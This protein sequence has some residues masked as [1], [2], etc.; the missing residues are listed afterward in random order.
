MRVLF[1]VQRYGPEVAG[2]AEHLCREYATRLAARGHDVHVLTSRALSYVDWSDHFP[3]GDT[4]VD[5]VAVHRLGV[6]A[7]RS[8]ALFGPLNARVAWNRAHPPVYLQEE[9]MRRSG[10][11]LAGLAP[12]LAKH[13]PQMDVVVFFTYLYYP[14]WAGLPL[15]ATLRPTVLHPTAHDEPPLYLPIFDTMF[16]HPSAF[17]FLT[18]EEAGLVRN[19]FGVEQPSAVVGVGVDAEVGSGDQGGAFRA[20]SAVG[21]RPYLLC[22]G[23]VDAAKGAE[24]LFDYFAAYKQR[25]PGPLALAFVGDPA[26]PLPPHPDVIVAG[27][28]EEAVKR[29]ALSGAM[30][31]VVPSFYE[32]FS[33]ALAEAWA[34]GKSALVQG[35]CPVLVGQARRSGGALRYEGF[36]EFE[37]VL[38]RLIA[39]Q[40]LR[41]RLGVAGREYVRRTACWDNVIGDYERF[42]STTARPLASE[43]SRQTRCR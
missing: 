24:E 18:E 12:W 27:R 33:I 2:G 35:H 23:R 13:V 22:L 9:W 3:A 28:V 41:A 17:G 6:S 1:V 34:H 25:Q 26:R 16:R 32:S 10:P 21:D 36:A 8:D 37:A 4:E 38:D 7:P 20:S 31:V 29:S 11:L 15:A 19:R 14:T 42:L 43:P 40:G 39:D 30:A 5:G